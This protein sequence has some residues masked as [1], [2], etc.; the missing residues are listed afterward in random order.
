MQILSIYRLYF[1]YEALLK[2]KCLHNEFLWHCCR[3]GN[4]VKC[5]MSDLQQELRKSILVKLVYVL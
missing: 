1:L 4:H 3:I 5:Q 2:L